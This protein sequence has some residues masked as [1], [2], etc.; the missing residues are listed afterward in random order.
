MDQRDSASDRSLL[1]RELATLKPRPRP[2]AS[3]A[4]KAPAPLAWSAAATASGT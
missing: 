2:L 4:L 3:T 1:A